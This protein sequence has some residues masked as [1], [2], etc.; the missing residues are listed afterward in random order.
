MRGAGQGK[1]DL[2][3]S[4]LRGLGDNHNLGG[5]SA[6][7][8]AD[9]SLAVSDGGGVCKIGYRRAGFTPPASVAK[10]P[11][12]FNKDDARSGSLGWGDREAVNSRQPWRSPFSLKSE[13]AHGVSVRACTPVHTQALVCAHELDCPER[14]Q[15]VFF[16]KAQV[17]IPQMEG[18][19]ITTSCN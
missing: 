14:G 8:G 16:L 1:Q 3:G 2:G 15:V 10:L 9:R 17:H 7:V 5:P 6:P 13:G 4:C 11:L 19:L 18:G 12:E